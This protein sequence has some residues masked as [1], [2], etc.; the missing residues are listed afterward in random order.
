VNSLRKERRRELAASREAVAAALPSI[1]PARPRPAAGVRLP[2]KAAA[3]AVPSPTPAFEA[4]ACGAPSPAIA[5]RIPGLR[6]LPPRCPTARGV[7]LAFDETGGLHL[8]ATPA[9]LGDLPA[10]SAWTRAQRELLGLACPQLVDLAAEAKRHVVAEDP[11]AA[12]PLVGSG[13]TVHL[14]APGGS[15][16]TLG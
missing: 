13:I 4:P 9:T 1:E 6:P 5:A 2:P 8:V 15:L 11:A 12:I 16:V 14:A 7:E 3:P 10:A